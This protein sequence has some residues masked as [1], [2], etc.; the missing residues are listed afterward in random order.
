[1]NLAGDKL[2]VVGKG[3]ATV[4]NLPAGDAKPVDLSD[5]VE[6]DLAAQSHQKFLEMAR[7]MGG[8]FYSPTMNGC[9]WPKLTDK[10][11]K[12]AD[13]ARTDEEFDYVANRFL[14]ELNASHLGVRSPG[15]DGAVRLPA[16]RIGARTVFAD[17]GFRIEEILRDGPATKG[18]TPLAVGDVIVAVNGEPVKAE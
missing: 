17:G 4:V 5:T 13:N 7:I 8:I 9:D 12:L 11:V 3:G 10:W 15:G 1:M 2:V 14:G 6:L 16:G 18:Q